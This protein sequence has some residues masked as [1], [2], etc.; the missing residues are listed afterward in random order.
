MSLEPQASPPMSELALVTGV[1]FN[2]SRTFADLG[3]RPRWF[4]PLLL[5]VL[6]TV[7]YLY[8]VSQHVGWERV[9]RRSMETN[10]RV[11]SLSAEQ[12]EQAVERGAKFGAVFG[13]AGAVLGV[14]ISLA[15]IAAVLLLTSRMMGAEL[16]YRQLFAINSYAGL[17]ALIFVGL[18]AVVLFL[19]PPDN[20]DI[21]NP[22]AFNIGAYLDPQSTPKAIYSLASSMDLFTFWRIALLAIGISAASSR[23]LSFG[24]GLAAVALPW[25]LMVFIKMGWAA[26]F[27]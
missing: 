27:G 19:I 18:S 11:Q 3:R 16:T 9:V 4:V 8:A 20:Y 6:A 21:Q 15:L 26:I 24:K 12:R 14:P 17:T 13:Y 22:V 25:G 2:P 7:A 10:A 1:F 5:V 23:A